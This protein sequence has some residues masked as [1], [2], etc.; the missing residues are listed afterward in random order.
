MK[1]NLCVFVFAIA[2][3]FSSCTPDFDRREVYV[4]DW[5]IKYLYEHTLKD[6]VVER[7]I[8]EFEGE[9][10][11]NSSDPDYLIR[12]EIEPGFTETYFMDRDGLLS[13]TNSPDYYSS[14]GSFF[15][16]DDFFVRSYIL[17]DNGHEKWAWTHSGK[18]ILNLN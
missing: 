12:I 15:T 11:A 6:S 17:N 9:V 2:V 5:E 3:V 1:T 18:R 7:E 16:E 4:G 13:L 14:T 10:I 8:V